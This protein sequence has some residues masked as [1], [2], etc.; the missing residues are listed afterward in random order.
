MKR[1]QG[2]IDTPRVIGNDYVCTEIREED[3]A[4]FLHSES[5][6]DHHQHV[7]LR[8][9]ARVSDLY[10]GDI[11]EISYHRGSLFCSRVF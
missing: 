2:P 1:F 4:Q 6:T 7:C 9:I 3:G 10:V 11:A 5:R 8:G